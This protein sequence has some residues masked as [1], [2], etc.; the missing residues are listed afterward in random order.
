[1]KI[2]ILVGDLHYT[3]LSGSELQAIGFAKE[4]SKNHK[5]FIYAKNAPKSL[6]TAS[7]TCRKSRYINFPLIRFIT[8]TL[9]AFLNIKKDM[10]DILLCY[11]TGTEFSAL[12]SKWLLKIPLVFKVQGIKKIKDK[13]KISTFSK[14]GLNKIILGSSDKIWLQTE[15]IKKMVNEEYPNNKSFVLSNGLELSEKRFCG[16]KILFIGRLIKEK[17]VQDLIKSVKDLKCAVIVV[18][19]GSERKK[20]E[21]IAPPNIIFTGY[22]AHE[23]LEDYFKQAYIFVLPSYN[24]GL[25]NVILEAMN[26]GLPVIAT[27]VGGIPDII[28]HDKTGFLVEPRDINGLRKYIQ[29]L[30]KDKKLRQRMGKNCKKEIKKYSWPIVAGEL[31]KNIE[32]LA[33]GE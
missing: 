31:V 14:F 19:E 25:P 28:E 26:V 9:S 11:S 12:L 1:M 15:T 7:L 16:S 13:L 2:G 20:L 5:V 30:L 6:N 4:L 23:K 33:K 24:E 22:I 8:S 10:P 27:K 17:G 32:D 18:G 29:L 21:K 3:K